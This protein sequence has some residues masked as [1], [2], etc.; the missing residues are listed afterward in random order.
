[1]QPLTRSLFLLGL[2]APS[3]PAQD[4]A[5]PEID[6]LQDAI[7]QGR[8][9]IHLNYRVEFADQ[10]TFDKDALAST[11]RTALGFESASYHGFRGLIEF[12]DI[13]NL[14]NDIYN[15]TT[16]GEANRPVVADPNS[17]EVNQVYAAYTGLENFELKIGRQEII[18]GN[19]RFVGNVAWRQNHQSFD[20]VRADWSAP[21]GTNLSYAYLDTVNRIF[22]E[23]NPAG[24]EQMASHLLDLRH[25]FEGVAW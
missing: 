14:G 2:L 3:T 7:Q 13:S 4:E 9:W 24:E 19:H 15:S 18:Y 10:D 1:M 6:S 12:E 21:S 17:T 20:A 23:D 8:T 16:N 5:V 11:L 25:T 22:G